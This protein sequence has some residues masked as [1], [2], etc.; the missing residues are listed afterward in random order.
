VLWQTKCL[1]GQ[2]SKHQKNTKMTV[3]V[4]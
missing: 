3:E 2:Y 4:Y 1:F